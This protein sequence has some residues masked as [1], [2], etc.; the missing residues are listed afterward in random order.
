ME[1]KMFIGN[2]PEIAERNIN[3]WLAK[4]NVTVSHITQSQSERNGSFV[5]VVSVFYT[6]GNSFEKDLHFERESRSN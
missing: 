3:E 4:E 2:K 1:V 6:N 5:F